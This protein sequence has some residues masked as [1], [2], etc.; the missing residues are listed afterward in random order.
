VQLQLG[1]TKGALDA[2]Q[3]ALGISR[4]LTEADPR[5]AQARRN[6][7]VALDGMGNVRLRLGD[8]KGAL[9]AYQELLGNSRKLAEAD[10]GSAEA[11]RDLSVALDRMGD[12]RLRLGDTKGA[13]D[14]YQESLGIRRKLAEADPRSAQARGDLAVSYRQL[15]K[16]AEQS[17]DFPA[18]V[19]WY[20]K[21]R[22]GLKAF[23]RPEV[24][25]QDVDSLDSRLNFCRFAAEHGIEDLAAIDGQPA[26]QQCRLLSAVQ[27]ALVQRKEYARAVRAAE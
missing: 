13:L 9:D 20:S 8:T 1:D 23:P 12:V 11:Q 7:S 6:L 10:P 25:K 27:G 17:S 2:Y 24:F 15:G 19:G 22:E 5:S 21:A 14:A 26:D 4:K 16:L 3:E 18:A